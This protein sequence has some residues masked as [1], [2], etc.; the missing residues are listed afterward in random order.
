MRARLKEFNPDLP[1]AA[2]DDAVR[3]IVYR[4][5]QKDREKADITDIIRRLHRVV[6]DAIET[7]PD[8]IAQKMPDRI[9]DISMIDFD[10]LR[11]EFERSKA[12]R[13]TVQN[14]KAA[15]ERRLALMLQRNPL[16]TNF[17][18]HY[19]DIVTDYNREKDRMTIERT[20]AELL[21]TVPAMDEEESRAMREG[22]DEE[23]LAVFD[24][25]KKPE[26]SAKEIKRI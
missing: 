2:Y 11:Q 21:R 19:E 15:I 1:E 7:R 14:L 20:F 23:T 12:K 3:Q 10:R 24:L 22:L 8:R 26:L 6:D 9:F 17:Q 4:S 5:L 13:T 16:R 25:L 18:Q